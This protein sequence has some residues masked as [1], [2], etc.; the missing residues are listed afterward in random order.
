MHIQRARVADPLLAPDQVQQLGAREQGAAGVV[1]GQEQ[2]IF[3]Q[4]ELDCRA[5]ARD[6]VAPAVD[7][8]RADLDA[9]AGL[10][11]ANRRQR[12][13][14][15]GSLLVGRRHHRHAAQVRADAGQQLAEAEGLD[16]VVVGPHVQPDDAIQLLAACRQHQDGDGALAAD[17]AADLEALQPGHH[18]IQQHQVGLL[19]ARQFQGG[20]AIIGNQHVKPLLAQLVLQHIDD[21][22]VVIGKQNRG[23]HDP[24]QSSSPRS[25]SPV[26]LPRPSSPHAPCGSPRPSSPHASCGSPRPSSPHAPC[27]GGA[28]R[29]LT[30]PTRCRPVSKGNTLT[31]RQLRRRI[32]RSIPPRGY[33][34][35]PP[36]VSISRASSAPSASVT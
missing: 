2:V 21:H 33:G 28:C 23:R 22:L 32:G 26:D 1:E 36:T 7:P 18:H 30:R 25:F 31:G 11:V 5:V 27:G 8:D 10:F 24:A 14:W 35:L 17:L 6:D 12:G 29:V 20:L 9:F 16:D 4:R 3:P 19:A 34:R 15:L 13:L